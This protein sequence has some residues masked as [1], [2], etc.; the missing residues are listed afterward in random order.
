MF[1]K[2]FCFFLEG[3]VFFG[4]LRFYCFGI[5]RPY[6]WFEEDMRFMMFFFESIRFYGA[7]FVLGRMDWGSCSAK[8]AQ[9]AMTI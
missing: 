5:L 9:K 1:G 3:S 6:C 4:C 8:E 2:V 7:L